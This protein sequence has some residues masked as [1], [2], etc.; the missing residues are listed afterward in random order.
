MFLDQHIN[1]KCTTFSI[2]RLFFLILTV[3]I[4]SDYIP[5]SVL[6]EKLKK[7]YFCK[8]PFL[9]RFAWTKVS[10]T[11]CLYFDIGLSFHFICSFCCFQ[12]IVLVLFPVGRCPTSDVNSV[13]NIMFGA[14]QYRILAFYPSHLLSCITKW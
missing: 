3:N 14:L 9:W 11:S 10:P 7:Y 2:L 5:S 13:A 8:A 4:D 12:Y 1:T 6:K